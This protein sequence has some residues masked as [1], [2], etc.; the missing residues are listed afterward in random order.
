MQRPSTPSIRRTRSGQ[1]FGGGFGFEGGFGV[2]L[3]G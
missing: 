1:G 3:A 2:G